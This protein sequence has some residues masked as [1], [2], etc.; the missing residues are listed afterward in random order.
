LLGAILDEDGSIIIRFRFLSEK[1]N[2]IYLTELKP[3]KV[4]FK[5]NP[6]LRLL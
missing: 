3:G 6:R 4:W 1:P 2:M 5:D